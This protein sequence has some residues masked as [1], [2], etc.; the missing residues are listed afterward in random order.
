MSKSKAQV[1]DYPQSGQLCFTAKGRKTKEAQ[2]DYSFLLRSRARYG[3]LT[4]TMKSKKTINF[5]IWPLSFGIFHFIKVI[6]K[7]NS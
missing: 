3:V 4:Q 1:N 2:S 5:V 6:K 7:P